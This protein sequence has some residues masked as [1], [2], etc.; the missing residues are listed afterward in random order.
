MPE[1]GR[2]W[3]RD[4]NEGGDYL[5]ARTHLWVVEA[6]DHCYHFRGKSAHWMDDTDGF[7]HVADPTPQLSQPRHR[8]LGGMED[9][10]RVQ[11]SRCLEAFNNGSSAWTVTL[12]VPR[13]ERFTDISPDPRV[14]DEDALSLDSDRR[15]VAVNQAVETVMYDIMAR[16]TDIQIDG[17]RAVSTSPR[18][19]VGHGRL[20][21]RRL[22]AGWYSAV[23]PS[24][25]TDRITALMRGDAPLSDRWAVAVARERS[26]SKESDTVT[27]YIE[28]D[29]DKATAELAEFLDV[30]ATPAYAGLQRID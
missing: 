14:H 26:R 20:V 27:V 16:T 4:T 7:V 10:Q 30:C 6:T 21:L 28:D 18:G 23:E 24:P 25:V 15:A 9:D 19:Q 8:A 11:C 1:N 3:E 13:Q 22:M 5:G 17:S 2:H 29:E 12:T